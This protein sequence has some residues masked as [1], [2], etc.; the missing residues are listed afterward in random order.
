MI[1]SHVPTR[2]WPSHLT[3][4]DRENMDGIRDIDGDDHVTSSSGNHYDKEASQEKKDQS[5]NQRD[6]ASEIH[7]VERL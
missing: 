3:S 2:K 1:N 5:G 7:D 6:T 4:V